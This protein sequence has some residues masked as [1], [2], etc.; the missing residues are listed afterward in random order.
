MQQSLEVLKNP[1]SGRFTW[2]VVSTIKNKRK[3]IAR[4]GQGVSWASKHGAKKG[5]ASAIKTCNTVL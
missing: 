1:R 3:I 2:Q 5:F 4:S